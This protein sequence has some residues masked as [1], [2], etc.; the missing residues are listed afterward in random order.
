MPPIAMRRSKK[1]Q[2]PKKIAIGRT[3]E[4][5][6]EKKLESV[7]PVNSTPY[8]RSCSANAGSTRVVTKASGWPS[9]ASLSAPMIF[10]SVIVRLSILP[11]RR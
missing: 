4:R 11:S 2:M 1:I 9:W 10:V 6:F 7:P 3:Q 5:R 8:C